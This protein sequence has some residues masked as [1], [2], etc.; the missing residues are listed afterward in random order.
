[1]GLRLHPSAPG[2]TLQPRV[3]KEAKVAK[4]PARAGRVLK[5]VATR[6]SKRAGSAQQDLL[7]GRVHD[8]IGPALVS[9]Y[10][11]CSAIVESSRSLHRLRCTDDLHWARS[12][13]I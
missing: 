5:K 11:V 1:M 3:A 10:C 4:V 8:Q 13:I 2:R 9:G 12:V 6:L 7:L